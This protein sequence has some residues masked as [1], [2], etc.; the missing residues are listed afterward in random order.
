MVTT[1]RLPTH[2]RHGELNV[3]FTVTSCDGRGKVSGSQQLRL[4][5][6]I[7]NNCGSLLTRCWAEDAHPTRL[8]SPQKNF[9]GSSKTRWRQYVRRRHRRRSLTSSPVHLVCRGVSS[10]LSTA[11]KYSERHPSTTGQNLC[12]RSSAYFCSQTVS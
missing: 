12:C 10:T 6:P 11:V 4:S 9:R 1:L 5:E 7:H 2:W 8:R 3:A